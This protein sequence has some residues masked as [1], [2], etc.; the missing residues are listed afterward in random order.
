MH[1][2]KFVAE[3]KFLEQP[4]K[5]SELIRRQDGEG[6]MELLTNRTVEKQVISAKSPGDTVRLATGTAEYFNL[7]SW[8]YASTRFLPGHP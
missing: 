2:G 3:A 1:Y 6:I 4:G 5:Y 7:K 8:E